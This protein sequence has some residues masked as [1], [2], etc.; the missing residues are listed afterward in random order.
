VCSEFDNSTEG[1]AREARQT[2]S[3]PAVVPA[4]A[5]QRESRA[6]DEAEYLKTRRAQGRGRGWRAG[7]REIGDEEA[8]GLLA[9]LRT[10]DRDHVVLSFESVERLLG[11]PLTP[12]QYRRNFWQYRERPWVKN[13]WKVSFAHVPPNHLR[14]YR[15]EVA[16]PKLGHLPSPQTGKYDLLVAYLDAL[17]ADRTVLSLE[18]LERV[19]GS[20]LTAKMRAKFSSL[21]T[22]E[23]FGPRFRYRITRYGVPDGHLAFVRTLHEAPQAV[24]KGKKTPRSIWDPFLRE[25]LRSPGSDS[26]RVFSFEEIEALRGVPLPD[27]A[28]DPSFW[29]HRRAC[30]WIGLGFQAS[31]EGLPPR[32]VRFYRAEARTRR[33]PFHQDVW[34]PLV[35]YLE[36]NCEKSLVLTFDELPQFHVGPLP[37]GV[38]HKGFWG[39]KDRPWAIAGFSATTAA[40]KTTKGTVYFERMTETWQDHRLKWER[41]IA[42]LE[43]HATT[44]IVLTL[45]T[46]EELYG[47]LQD[48]HRTESW[49]W[50]GKT[51]TWSRAGFACYT[52]DKILREKGEVLFVR[53][54][55][56]AGASLAELTVLPS[57]WKP[58]VRGGRP[59]H[60]LERLRGME[61]G[62]ELILSFDELEDLIGRPLPISARTE[63]GFWSGST[64]SWSTAGFIAEAPADLRREGRVRFRRQ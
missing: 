53:E 59:R 58:S 7:Q 52:T 41:L 50:T 18:E 54:E 14:F 20:P 19:L 17:G 29:S 46:I 57:T 27:S 22:A 25:L 64:R 56:A 43:E 51:R 9:Y 47:E 16:D 10:Q 37:Q 31:Y 11:R 3:K 24:Q 44:H 39:G 28:A 62:S 2:P 38:S 21:P 15:A 1:S 63:S 36:Q 13:G 5:A 45:A 4:T 34:A 60:L 48:Y 49:F 61:P 35:S 30:P 42:F 40:Q 32:H 6:Q 55:V 33:R 26:G 8:K 23:V 12:Y